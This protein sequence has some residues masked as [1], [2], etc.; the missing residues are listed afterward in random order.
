MIPKQTYDEVQWRQGCTA[1]GL[2]ACL[3]PFPASASDRGWGHSSSR[4]PLAPPPPRVLPCPCDPHPSSHTSRIAG[5]SR[6][7]RAGV[8]WH[9]Q[10]CQRWSARTWRGYQDGE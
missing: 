9:A 8:Y 7:S 6:G 5:G 4:V 3:Y 1:R 10:S 2:T